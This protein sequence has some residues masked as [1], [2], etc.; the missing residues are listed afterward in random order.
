MSRQ[1]VNDAD[2]ERLLSKLDHQPSDAG[3]TAQFADNDFAMDDSYNCVSEFTLAWQNER[4]APELLPCDLYLLDDITEMLDFQMTTVV[5]KLRDKGKPEEDFK[6]VLYET[7]LERVRFMLRSYLRTRLAK[8][9]KYALHYLEEYD[10]DEQKRQ[11]S[12]SGMDIEGSSGSNGGG[13]GGG[14]GDGGMGASPNNKVIMTSSEYEYAV[15][16]VELQKQYHHQTSLHML[17][18]AMQSIDGT[19]EGED[20]MIVRPNLDKAVICRV[21]KDIGHVDVGYS[22][23]TATEDDQVIMQE[24]N[25]FILNYSKVR[26]LL[27]D[28][29]IQLI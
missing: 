17:P 24:G 11:E 16:Y 28:G 4:W 13:G 10:Q 25:V 9:E 26:K 15:R 29:H 6:A 18:E 2:F 19:G 20:N 7:E 12:N 21:L 1:G 8:I 3:S 27:L 22:S 14:G 23:E 5:D